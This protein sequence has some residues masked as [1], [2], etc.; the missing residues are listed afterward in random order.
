VLKYV[1]LLLFS[2][3]LSLPVFGQD[4]TMPVSVN[5]NRGASTTFTEQSFEK[6]PRSNINLNLDL[7][8]WSDYKVSFPNYWNTYANQ[9][10]ISYVYRY[11]GFQGLVYKHTTRALNKYYEKALHNTWDVSHLSYLDLDDAKKEY[12]LKAS[13]PPNPWWERRYFFDNFPI[14]K[15][16]SRVEG[17]IIGETV[18]VFSLGPLSLKN[19][20]KLSWNGWRL[21]I[22]TERE[23]PTKNFS[24][25][26]DGTSF[27]ED[28]EK[29]KHYSFGISLPRG[30]LYTGS[31]WSISGSVKI[32]L[33][34]NSFD[35]N[36]S[37]IAGSL[38]ILGHT[39]YR[40]IPRVM[41]NIKGKARP[42]INDYG[43]QIVISVL[44]F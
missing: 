5:P 26:L 18:D 24:K 32:G 37:S 10:H 8:N 12:A 36:R 31:N 28:D 19:S 17:I 42:V 1:S 2:I 43:L 7:T 44:T 13:D 22:S 40:H 4:E 15:G 29:A 6:N 41:I 11:K 23:L 39:G 38:K 16:G 14:E 9:P 21:T 33:K 34:V 25:D 20:G 30:N 3:F 27:E 35:K